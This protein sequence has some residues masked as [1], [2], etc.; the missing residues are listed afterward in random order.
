MPVKKGVN[1]FKGYQREV[2]KNSSDL[3]KKVI[4][5]LP[6]G[7]E[8]ESLT[9]F[10]NYCADKIGVNPAT[11]LRKTSK[12]RPLIARAYAQLNKDIS[13]ISPA[14]DSVDELRSLL[15]IKESEI[16]QKNAEIKRLKMVVSNL[17][18][19]G[20]LALLSHDDNKNIA[21]TD[22][23]SKEIDDLCQ[24]ITKIMGHIEKLGISINDKGELIDNGA[25]Y[26][27]TIADKAELSIYLKWLK[28]REK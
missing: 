7:I 28:A 27:E 6:S 23:C 21:K 17:M 24:M 1:N 5:N 10:A 8:F 11:L 19:G 25:G 15:L 12:Y 16:G 20:E 14:T 13:M 22:F 3:L 18:P 2:V 4:D 26:V 9:A